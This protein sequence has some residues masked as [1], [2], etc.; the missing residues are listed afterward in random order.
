MN[1]EESFHFREILYTG[2]EYPVSRKGM[3]ELS[4]T[5]VEAIKRL[6]K[7]PL[8]PG[9]AVLECYPRFYFSVQNASQLGMVTT[10]EPYERSTTTPV[11]TLAPGTHL[12]R[13]VQHVPLVSPPHVTT[14]KSSTRSMW[15][16]WLVRKLS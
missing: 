9:N 5:F 8:A 2:E 15:T 14:Q 16:T 12:K 7:Q 4:A 10:S 6:L 1:D 13:F 11:T 3:T